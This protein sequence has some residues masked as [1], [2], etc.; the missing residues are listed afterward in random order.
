M[1]KTADKLTIILVSSFGEKFRVV[2][3]RRSTLYSDLCIRLNLIICVTFADHK[4]HFIIIYYAHV[5]CILNQNYLCHLSRP[6]FKLY[7]THGQ[8]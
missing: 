6:G 2:C 1:R 8:R 3:N 5:N 7:L 4:L